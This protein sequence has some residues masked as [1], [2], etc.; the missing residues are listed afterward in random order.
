MN[1]FPH[2]LSLKYI[3]KKIKKKKQIFTHEKVKKKKSF[4]RLFQTNFL[5]FTDGK[6]IFFFEILN[7]EKC[8]KKV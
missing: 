1:I 8:Q 7:L 5:A 2:T 3:K 6:Q 4:P